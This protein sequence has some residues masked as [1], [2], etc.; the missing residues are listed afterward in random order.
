M[1]LLGPADADHFRVKVGRFGDRFYCDP[2]PACDIAGATDA[3]WPS[4]STVKKAS[5]QDWSYVAMKRCAAAVF[6]VGPWHADKGA[7]DVY[8]AFKVYDKATK[9]I[10]FNRGTIIHLWFEDLLSGEPPRTFTPFDLE[11]NKLKPE[12]LDEATRYLP[13]VKAWF[14]TYEPQLVAKE[15]V[16]IHRTLNGVGYGGT[17]DAIISI[18]GKTYMADWKSRG[19]DHD[20]YAEEAAQVAA[21]AGAEY[22]IVVGDDGNP[23]RRRLPAFEGG[24][25][26]SI[27]TD[28][29]R[30]YPVTL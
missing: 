11:V 30:T 29:C 9:N 18:D 20:A 4:I 23:V 26:V 6:D 2:L 3:T 19:S 17:A 24:L 28:G 14:D 1:T 25:I 21:L 13:A 8:E 22:M 5:G 12:A 10:A 15:V 16:C 27:K 7:D